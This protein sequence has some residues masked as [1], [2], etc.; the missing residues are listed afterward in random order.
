M[1][2]AFDEDNGKRTTP[3]SPLLETLAEVFIP[4]GRKLLLRLTA[5]EC[6]VNFSVF[7]RKRELEKMVVIIV[8]AERESLRYG[9]VA[10][11]R[12]KI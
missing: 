4:D 6:E 1:I 10:V 2:K 9:V 12:G 7:S 11:L 3:P 8:V 5:F